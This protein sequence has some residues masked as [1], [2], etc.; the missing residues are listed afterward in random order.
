MMHEV[1]RMT[2]QS[3]DLNPSRKE[4][5]Y[6]KLHSNFVWQWEICSLNGSQ[7]TCSE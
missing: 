1:S 6:K 7:W 2:E 3:T 4:S 5:F